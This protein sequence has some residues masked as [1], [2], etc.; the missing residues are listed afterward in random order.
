MTF[1]PRMLKTGIAVTLA[2]YISTWLQ[3]SPPVISAVAAIFAMQPTIYRSW[4]YF[5]DQVQTNTL[6]AVMAV[7]AGTFFSNE[8]IAIGVVCVLAIMCCIKL[9]MEETIGLT[10]VTVVAVMEA[11]GAGQWEFALNRFLLS[12][13][14]IVSA[15]VINITVLPPKP[16]Q[17]FHEQV[18]SV[19]T[20]LSL[21]LRTAISDEIKEKVFRDQKQS[22]QDSLVSLA[23]KYKL[24]EEEQKK[25]K[26][27]KYRL[28]RQLVV[29]KQMLYTLQKG[30][31]VLEAVQEHFF[32]AERTPEMNKSYDRHLEKMI[33]FHEHVLLKFDDRL[34]PGSWDSA[35]AET[36]NDL[37]MQRATESC[38]EDQPGSRR[39]LIVAATIYDYGHQAARLNRMIEH[40]DQSDEEKEEA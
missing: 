14:G 4:R 23:A 36:A 21:L 11:S 20:Q 5:L 33:K 13:I 3:F 8:P 27:A 32:Q 26:R 40:V 17:Q 1:G 25:L 18:R 24:L 39:L 38:K 29:D 28:K 10:L 9:K 31:E 35:P 37:F 7:L 15:F 34:K 22:L 30:Y 6:G 16:K 19:F 2:L 12:L